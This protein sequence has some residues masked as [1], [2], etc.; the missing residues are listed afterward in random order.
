MFPV[1]LNFTFYIYTLCYIISPKIEL[2][3]E[4]ER[5]EARRIPVQ[6]EKEASQ[7]LIQVQKEREQRRKQGNLRL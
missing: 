1:I 2:K 7:K 4:K 5:E 3:A 6:K